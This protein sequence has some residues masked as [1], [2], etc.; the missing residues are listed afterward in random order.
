MPTSPTGPPPPFPPISSSS[1]LTTPAAATVTTPPISTA[2]VTIPPISSAPRT[3]HNN[4]LNDAQN[5][6]KI[7]QSSIHN[8]NNN[9]ST[10]SAASNHHADE[11]S[12]VGNH[13]ESASNE[14][15]QSKSKKKS[16]QQ[17]STQASKK[18]SSEKVH[19][20]TNGLVSS[21]K[22][23]AKNSKNN[24]SSVTNGNEDD[25]DDELL[26]KIKEDNMETRTLAF[27][28]IRRL[29]RDYSGLYEQLAKVK[30]SFEM[31]FSFV[32]MCIDEAARFRRKHMA[33]CIQEWWASQCDED[34]VVVE[35]KT[36][37]S[38]KKK[39]STT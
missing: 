36:P 35:K 22:K 24:V 1:N 28:E 37:G 14:K 12:S 39:R 18:N 15:L 30:G 25:V 2:S 33:D 4:D 9:T 13:K 38:G 19:G 29:G 31:R 27:R 3:I 7:L 32:Q 5:I 20:H 6:S 17:K 26:E 10:I 8:G 34:S 16:P 23:V 21:D 11:V